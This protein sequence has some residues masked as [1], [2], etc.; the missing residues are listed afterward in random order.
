MTK[1]VKLVLDDIVEDILTLD[2]NAIYH[3]EGYIDTELDF[4]K[5][6]ESN[7]TGCVIYFRKGIITVL[8]I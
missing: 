3:F 7:I 5:L 8:I 1:E 2:E 4:L 6:Y